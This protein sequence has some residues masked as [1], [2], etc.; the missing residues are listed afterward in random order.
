MRGRAHT[1]PFRDLCDF[2][3]SLANIG[4]GNGSNRVVQLT[5]K[6]VSGGETFTLVIKKPE[7]GSVSIFVNGVLKTT[8]FTLDFQTGILTFN[9]G[10]APPN[11]HSVAWTGN[12][13]VPARY[14]QDALDQNG[15]AGF[16]AGGPG[17]Y[18][19]NLKLT[20]VRL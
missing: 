4:T 13:Y 7:S 9:V 19:V 15:I 12:F 11:G 2:S 10:Q 3:V 6:Y 16:R 20:E 14:D 8:G 5:K 18:A 17:G 1:F